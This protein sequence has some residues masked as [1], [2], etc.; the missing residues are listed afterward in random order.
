MLKLIQNIPRANDGEQHKDNNVIKYL[1]FNKDSLLNLA[2]RNYENFVEALT[3]N[4]I[5]TAANSSY[6]LRY[7]CRNL[8]L[9]SQTHLIRYVQNRRTRKLS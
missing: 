8:H 3:N 2:E 5:Y 6:I 7:R 4:A 1:E 9:H